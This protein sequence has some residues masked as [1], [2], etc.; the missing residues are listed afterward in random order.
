MFDIQAMAAAK[1]VLMYVEQIECLGPAGTH[2]LDTPFFL[3]RV[4]GIH[5]EP[6]M[7]EGV[8]PLNNLHGH[9][10]ATP[11][12]SALH[13]YILCTTSVPTACCAPFYLVACVPS[14]VSPGA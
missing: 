1:S 11:S 2:R 6:I 5:M 13:V 8:T 7:D 12:V 14:S 10:F 9:F 3:V 4:A